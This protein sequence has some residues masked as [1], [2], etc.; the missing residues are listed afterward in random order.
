MRERPILFKGPMVRAILDGTKTQT[1][2]IVKFS[3]WPDYESLQDKHRVYETVVQGG[4]GGW[5]WLAGA[6]TDGRFSKFMID[7]PGK[8]CP[9]GEVGDRLWV[10]ETFCDQGCG[11]F[12]YRASVE[13]PEWKVRRWRPSI[14][15]PRMA[16]R[17][18]LE[19]TAIRASRLQD[20]S[21]EDAESEGA[22]TWWNGL[23]QEEQFGMYDG[24]RG[25]IAAF[26]MLWD[27]INAKRGVGWDVNPL[28]W[29]VSFRREKP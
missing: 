16:S 4:D 12:L 21:E 13:N 27:S 26:R 14:F 9:Y 24:G 3:S 6:D 8:R 17:I 25:P 11:R 19:V 5:G 7:T 2:R 20:I 29:A 15:M 1:R 22:M 28:V 23:S 10:R 18:E